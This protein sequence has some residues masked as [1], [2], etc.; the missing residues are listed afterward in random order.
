[1]NRN[2]ARTISAI[3]PA[4]IAVSSFRDERRGAPDLDDLDP[5]AGLDDVVVV[6]RPRG[7][8]L[9]VD[10]HA[11]DALAVGDPLQHHAGAAHERRRAGAQ[12]R[13][14]APVRARERPERGE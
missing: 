6:V 8:Y 1:M 3:R 7:P 4:V 5:L 12:L 2:T 13:R 14:L 10:P 11:A 9:A